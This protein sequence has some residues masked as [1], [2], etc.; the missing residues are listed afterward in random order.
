MIRARAGMRQKL[1]NP[2]PQQ[3][4]RTSGHPGVRAPGPTGGPQ[5]A[6]AATQDATPVEE[7]P[8]LLRPQ[9]ECRKGEE[10]ANHSQ[11]KDGSSVSTGLPAGPIT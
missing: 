5:A 11:A 7:R 10:R 4:Y 9:Q 1:I 8:S 6:T 3:S 2:R